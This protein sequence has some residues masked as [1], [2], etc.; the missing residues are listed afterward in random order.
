MWVF[1]VN[2]LLNIVQKDPQCLLCVFQF[3]VITISLTTGKLTSSVRCG[4]HDN[5]RADDEFL[6]VMSL[7]ENDICSPWMPDA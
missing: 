4:F 5:S 1:F 3:D 2:Y 6:L 7:A